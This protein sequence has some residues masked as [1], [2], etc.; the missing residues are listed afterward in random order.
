MPRWVPLALAL[1]VLGISSGGVLAVLAEGVEPVPKTIWRTGL[2]AL[3]LAPWWR[4]LPLRDM[5]LMALAG[6][7]LAAHFWTWFM[8]LESISVMRSVVLVTLA[9]VWV[10][11]A[12]WGLTGEAPARRFWA[13]ISVALVGVVT[14]AWAGL[15]EANLTGDLLALV[16]GMFSS[17]YFLLGRNLRQRVHQATYAG[18]VSGFSALWLLPVAFVLG[19]PLTGY[20]MPSWAALVGLALLPQLLGHGGFNAA[21]G[22][23]KATRVATLVLLEPVGATLLAFFVLGQQ[24]S[25]LEIVGGVFILVGVAVG[26]KS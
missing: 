9:P 20:A 22:H 8:S 4:K 16:G 12:E 5:G 19:T 11:L 2:C 10:G 21:L 14:M 6:A 15:G 24:P 23:V 18:M 25:V 7:L 1:A 17:A 13:G 26:Q 3:V